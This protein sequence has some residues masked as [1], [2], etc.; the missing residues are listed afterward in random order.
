[1]ASSNPQPQQTVI[2]D[3][4]RV[5]SRRRLRACHECDLLVALPPLKPHQRAN[6]PRCDHSLS[7]RHY[8]P[9][10]RSLAFAITALIALAASLCFPFISFE[11]RGVSNAIQLTDT[12]FSLVNFHEPFVG[13]LVL[14]TIVILPVAY[15]LSV[16]WLQIGLLRR[17]PLPRS[18]R[19][20]RAL[21]HL[22]PWM[23]ADVFVIGALVSLIKIAGMASIDLGLSFWAFCVYALMLLLTTRSLDTDWMWF[24]LEGEPLAPEGCRVGEP[25]AEQ[26][27]TGCPTCGLVNR[28]SHF[29]RG[30]CQRCGEPLRFRSPHSVQKTWALLAAAT[31][32]YIPAN[33]YPIMTTTSLG[34]ATPSTIIGGVLLFIGHGDW[35]IALVIFTASVVV[36]IGKVFA[37]AWLCIRV[38]RSGESDNKH[39][40]LKLYRITEFIGRW[41]MIDVF[42]VSILVALVHAGSLLSITPGPAALA[43]A[44][45]VVITMLAANSFDAR[46]IWDARDM[47]PPMPAVLKHQ[48]PYSPVK[49]VDDA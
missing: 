7:H 34:S 45:V 46:L 18:R 21:S 29:G 15:L 12:A 35:P 40:R 19:I 48:S 28:L 2:G 39:K 31:I 42:V 20:A 43:F 1:M 8:R 3:N 27:M 16:I 33:L 44:A 6:C 24:S 13:V 25:A 10:E 30:R 47:Q 23:M 49:E 26:G 37:L 22:T 5:R 9:A 17:A 36:P 11:A 41:S 32:F 14:L 4:L 38:R